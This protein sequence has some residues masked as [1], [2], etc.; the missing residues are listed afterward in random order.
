MTGLELTEFVTDDWK[1]SSIQALWGS[2]APASEKTPSALAGNVVGGRYQLLGELGRGGMGAGFRARELGSGREVAVK[3]V[4]DGG[5]GSETRWARFVR[6]GELVATLNHPGIVRVHSAGT[7]NGKPFLVYELVE[8]CQTLAEAVEGLDLSER[9]TLLRDVARGLGAAHAQ[10]IV[11]RDVKPGNI[12]VDSSG[13]ARI[14]DFGLATALDLGRLTRTGVMIGTPTH[15]APEQVDGKESGP[16]TPATDVWALGVILYWV[17]TCELPFAAGSWLELA[18]QIADAAPSPPRA[19][20]A[21]L[22]ADLEAACLKCL[23]RDPRERYPDAEAFARELDAYLEG[24][25]LEVRPVSSASR[26]VRRRKRSFLGAG[27][28]MLVGALSVTAVAVL[29]PEDE[30]ALHAPPAIHLSAPHDGIETRKATIRLTGRVSPPTLSAVAR[31]GAQEWAI[32]A[33][34]RFSL[35]VPLEPGEN[36]IAV[37]AL[38]QDGAPVGDVETL[39]VHFE[40]APAW[41]QQLHAPP[42]RPL[43]EG[44]RFGEARGEF[45]ARDG[46]VLVWVP[47]GKFSMGLDTGL[48]S[49]GPAHE[50]RFARGYFIGK[51]EL[52]WKRYRR[53]LDE[54]G[55]APP[56][57]KPRSDDHPAISMGWEDAAAYCAWAGLRLPTEAEWEYAARGPGGWAY[58]WG[59]DPPRPGD[60]NYKFSEE[61]E[62]SLAPVGH[63]AKDLSP[64]GCFDMG[65]NLNEWVAD[66]YAAY[67]GRPRVDPRVPEPPAGSPPQRLFRGGAFSDGAGTARSVARHRVEASFSGPSLGFR[68]ACSPR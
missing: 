42:P 7:E 20:D 66:W 14:T 43:P 56:P 54:T 12:L 2:Q 16:P 4:L 32:A 18:V 60:F 11:H 13:A 53:F 48:P 25:A 5:T 31:L 62:R 24:R 51:Y 52:T 67:P 45:V 58:P 15:M 23:Q 36:L 38:S 6:E 37:Q 65:G 41:F 35:E 17:M 30:P 50:V 61:S 59:D 40:D 10:G 9:V 68:V 44:L 3:L 29:S 8:G 28:L 63:Y 49:E 19:L 57:S 21:S 26:F 22:P 34:E 47:P 1:F 39:R 33:G 46:S 64:V 55:R 27:T